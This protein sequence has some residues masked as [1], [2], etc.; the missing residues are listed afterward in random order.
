MPMNDHIVHQY[1]NE[2]VLSEDLNFFPLPSPDAIWWRSQLREKRD[3]AR[4]SV[5]AI[6]T[7]RMAALVVSAASAAFATFVWVPRMFA[8]L[9]LP[10]P[11]TEA[12]LVL[13]TCS[14]AGVLLVWAR[15]R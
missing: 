14:T 3:L 10:L 7:V 9:P 12:S 5:L 2:L 4:R 8:E 11:V 13:F 6:D 15:Q 1:L